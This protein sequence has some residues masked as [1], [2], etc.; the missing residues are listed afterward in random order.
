LQ[1]A[2]EVRFTLLPVS[3][4][5]ALPVEEKRRLGI[6]GGGGASFL[7]AG[8]EIDAGWKLFGDKRRENYD[9][10]WRCEVTFPPALDEEFGVTHSKQGVNPSIVV[11]AVLALDLEAIARELN[12]K[13]REAFLELKRSAPSRAALV[14]S[15]GDRRLPV[16][17]LQQRL[18][19][20]A[21]MTYQI[22]RAALSSAAFFRTDQREGKLIITLNT[23]HPFFDRVYEPLVHSTDASA[24]FALELLLLAAGRA[25]FDVAGQSAGRTIG[26]YREAWSDALVAFLDAQ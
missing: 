11:K 17:R 4:W 22:Q 26:Q 13:I 12:G 21:G 3:E 18:C 8:R 10:W 14:A 25:E 7:R 24:Q 1:A 5:S 2:V 6:V 19:G 23:K 15:G 16:T 9:D 20:S